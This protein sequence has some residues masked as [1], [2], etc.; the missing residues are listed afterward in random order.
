[1]PWREQVT[2]DDRNFADRSV[3]TLRIR[4]QSLARDKI[5]FPLGELTGAIWMADERREH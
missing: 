5:V 3:K 1:L 4:A 2:K